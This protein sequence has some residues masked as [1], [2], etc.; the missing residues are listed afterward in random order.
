MDLAAAPHPSSLKDLPCPLPPAG[1]GEPAELAYFRKQPGSDDQFLRLRRSLRET[2]NWSALATLLVLHAASLRD[3]AKVAELSFQAYELW[4]DRAK[5]KAQAAHALVRALQAQPDNV[6]PFDLLRR[7]Y[8]QL[9]AHRELAT[10]LRWRIDALKR[11]DRNAVPAALVELGLLYEQ[12][13]LDIPEACALYRKALELAPGDRNASEQLIR[14][15]MAAGAWL[16]AIDLMNAELARTDPARGA[17]DKARF[18]ELHLRLAKIEAQQL[19]NIPGAALHLQSALKAG[20]DNIAALR[21][22]GVLYLGSGKATDDGLAKAADVFFRAAKLARG[23]G[24]D[25]QALGLLRRTLALKPDHFEAG[26]A[27]AELLAQRERWMELDD[28]YAA[29]L[30]YVSDADSYGLWLQRGELLEH[31]LARREEARA[32][33]ENATRFEPP[34]GDAWQRL[35]NLL[36]ELSDHHGL[37]GLIERWSEQDPGSLPSDRLLRAA[38]IAREELADEERAAVFFFKVLEREPFNAEA[39]EG[40]KEHWRRKANWSHLAD[41]LLYQIDQAQQITGPH[42]PLARSEFAENFV[43]LADIYER[44]LGD[45]DAA[46]GAWNRLAAAYPGDWR[47][48]EQIGRIDKRARMLDNMVTAQEN[49]LV[50]TAEPARRFEVLRRLTQAQRE[51]MTDPQRTITLYH[52]MLS[53]AP[54]DANTLKALGEMYERTGA[55]D[56]VIDLLRRQHDVTRSVSQ[57]VVLLRRMAEIWHNEL[58][59]PREALWACEQ[60]L[61]Y[62]QGDSDALRRM[63]ALCAEL[64]EAAGEFDALQRELQLV[65]EPAARSRILRRMVDVSER[66]LR[67]PQRTAQ[68]CSQ[69][70]AADPHN[71]E[72]LDK[73]IG[74]YE[75]VGR[76]EE[77]ASLLGKAAASAKT[78]PIRQLDYLMRLGNLAETTLADHDLACSA[79]E[80]V[81]RIH[82]DHRGAVEALTRLYRALGSWHGLAAT[83]GTLQEMSD[84]DEDAIA[85]G[86][87]RADVLADHLD[88]PAAAVRVLEQLANT[89]AVGHRDIA[90]KL[91][92]L[93]ERAGQFDK[94]IRHAELMLL[95]TLE[96]DAR[97]E[98]FERIARTWL[99]HFQNQDKALASFKRFMAE[100]EDDSEG[101]QIMGELQGLTGDHAGTLATL[102]RSLEL[103]DNP[104]EQVVTL[105]QMAEVCEQGLG[106]TKRA[107]Q[108]L[109]R[110][111]GIAPGS[112]ELKQKIEAFA[113]RHRMWK[114]LL[115]VYA[116]LF[117]NMNTRGE[118]RSQIDLCV[119]ASA[120]AE[121]R[122]GDVD[123][124]FMWAKKA[125]FVALRAGMDA[126]PVLDRLEGLARGHNLWPQMLEV[127]EQELALQESSKS[128]SYGDYGTIALLMSAAEIARERLRDPARSLGFLT[129]AYKLRPED[130]ELARQIE[131]LAE[132]HGLW[133][134]IIDLHE[135]RLAREATT[136]L[137]RF[138]AANAIAKVY[139]RQ[140]GAPEKAFSYLR[141]AWEDVQLKEPSLAEEIMDL[142]TQ[143]ARR[144]GLWSQL[145]DHNRTLA[146]AKA[147][148]GDARGAL[149]SLREA[150]RIE[151]EQQGDAL[152]ALRSL[153]QAVAHDPAHTV[154]PKVRELSAALDAAASPGSPRLGALALLAVL[155]QMIGQT[156]DPNA[157]INLLKQRAEIREKQLGDGQ[158][159][160]AEWMR[161]LQI[162]AASEEARFEL[163]RL[164]DRDNLW[165]VMLLVPAWELAQKPGK[166]QQTRLLGQIA[167]LYEGP[168]ARPEYALRTRIA[169]W[170]L[171]A[172]GVADLPVRGELSQTHAKLWQLAAVVGSFTAPPAPKDPLL[173][174]RISPPELAD[175]GHWHKLGLHP[176]NFAPLSAGAAAG[177]ASETALLPAREKTKIVD[178]SD[179]EEVDEARPTGE[180]VLTPEEQAALRPPR[181]NTGVVDL[182]DVEELE[183]ARLTGEI[184]L[185]DEQL[186]ALGHKRVR[187]PTGKLALDDVEDIEELEARLTGEIFLTDAEM[188]ALRPPREN[189]GVVDVGDLE[190]VDE[191]PKKREQTNIV[192]I[193]ELMDEADDDLDDLDSLI[194]GATGKVPAHKPGKPALPRPQPGKPSARP[195]APKQPVPAVKAVKT[196]SQKPAAKTV[197]PAV[198]PAAHKPAVKPAAPP[199]DKG[200]SAEALAAHKARVAAVTVG[201]PP[202]PELQ[203]PVLASRPRAASAWDE[204]AAAYATT[205]A[206]TKAERAGVALALARLWNEGAGQ[207]DHAFTH[208]EEALVLT[209]EDTAIRDVLER[210]ADVSSRPSGPDSGG[211]PQRVIDA[212]SRLLGELTVPEHIVGYGLRLAD[213][214]ER[215][216]Q[217]DRAEEQYQAV[218]GVAPRE[219]AALRALARI[220]ERSG[221]D[222]EYVDASTRLLDLEL[223]ELDADARVARTLALAHDLVVRVDR[224]VD[225]TRRLEALARD[226]PRYPQAHERL[227]DLLVRQGL[228]TRAVEALRVA[229]TAVP[230]PEFALRATARVAAL[231]EEQLQNV[232]QA[233]AAWSEIQQRRP[234]DSEAL[235]QLQRL[236]LQTE[237]YGPLLPIVDRR[238]ALLPL[239]DREGRI[240]L[241]VAKARALQEG[242]GN[243][244]AA[245]ETLETLAAEAPENDDVLLGLSR[246][247]RKRGRLDEGLALL[248]RRLV[249]ARDNPVPDSDPD[250]SQ[251]AARILKLSG[252][253]ADALETE[254]RDPRAALAAIDAALAAVPVPE[255]SEPAPARAA[256]VARKVTLARAMGDAAALIDGLTALAQPDGLLEAATLA[257]D[258]VGDRELATQLYTRVL[259]TRVPGDPA[260]QKRLSAAI[261]GLVRLR[262]EAGDI[263]GADALMD[264]QLAEL[265]D[266]ELRARILTEI[267]RTLLASLSLPEP[268]PAAAPGEPDPEPT[269]AFSIARELSGELDATGTF[270]VTRAPTVP[271][272]DDDADDELMLTQRRAD[273]PP[274]LAEPAE[275]EDVEEV[276]A[277]EEVEEL[278]AL[279]DDEPATLDVSRAPPPRKPAASPTPPRPAAVVAAAT[280][281][282]PRPRPVAAPAPTGDRRTTTLQAARRRFEAALAADPDHA[283]ARLSLGTVLYDLGLLA[284]AEPVLES[285][286]EAFGLVRDQENLVQGLCLL[287]RLFEHTDRSAEAYRRLSMALRHDP[288]NLEIRA[289]MARNRYQAGRWRDTL[290]AIEPIEQRLDAGLAVHGAQ[291]ELVSDLLL[292][293]AECD[294]QLKQTDRLVARFE[295]AAA[296]HP[297]SRKARAALAQLC[298]DSGRLAEAAEHTRALAEFEP[299]RIDRGRALMRAGMLFHEAA[300]AT[301]E[302]NEETSSG[303][304]VALRTAA[305][306]CVDLGLALIADEPAASLDRRQLEAAFWTAA[307]RHAGIALT[308]LGRLLGHP[309]LTPEHRHAIL[310]EGARIALARR[311]DGDLERALELATAATV[312]LPLVASGVH[313][314]F[315]AHVAT[316]D[317]RL[318]QIETA[319]LSFF[320]RVGRDKPADAREVQ[321]RQR[322]LARLAAREADHPDRAIRL[323]ERA[324]A[325]DPDTLSLDARRQLAHLYFAAATEGPQVRTNDEA[326]LVLDP[327]DERN[328]A[329][330]A[331]HCADNNDRDRAHALYQVL[332]VVQPAHPDATAFLGKND[333]SHVSNG[334]LD[335]NTVIDKPPAGGGVVAAMTQLWEGAA[336]LICEELPRLEISAAAWIEADSDKDTLLWKVW[337]ELGTQISTTGVR[338]ADAG[339]IP[340]VTVQQWA[341]PRAAHPPIVMIGEIA[342][343]TQMAP[344][345][346]FV[347]GRALFGTRPAAAPVAGL[348]RQLSAT[349][350]AA[351]LQA[352]HP[353]HTRR[354]RVR[355]DADLATRLAQT[356]ARKLPIRLARQLSQFFKDHEAE[357]FDSRDWR[358]WVARSGNRV[359]LCLARNLGVALDVLGLPSD[360]AERSAALKARAAHDADLRDLLVFATRP[361]YVA[362]RKTLGFEVR[363]R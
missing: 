253:L 271:S 251:T 263:E 135:S 43:E 61:G 32:C 317:D 335:P 207:P 74:V 125:Y 282:A 184:L 3:P 229:V 33:Y 305:F 256:L 333:L 77:L 158:G 361:T 260:Q 123:L 330:L 224:L 354:T 341:D 298:E 156:V 248:E 84:T 89:V 56:Q 353:R 5:D 132:T 235:A 288:D 237:Q 17:G 50:R 198:K 219:R 126:G 266:A 107:L 174:P 199:P 193:A 26:N 346:R 68:A 108:L 322:L 347:L 291:A 57:R 104:A 236:Y 148:K 102:E 276:D 118:S 357:A 342:R 51:R 23:Q 59:Q 40:Y 88:N 242:L 336:E 129:R 329:S 21:A 314:V 168:L 30:G 38:R 202:L 12:Q 138:E 142:L 143:L 7:L 48:R 204:L 52:E 133:Q 63:Q 194:A 340:G 273:E 131:T 87:E 356:F 173:W 285:A 226:Y 80:R 116:E 109:G 240:T 197:K 296:L 250:G 302:N 304:A 280:A 351:A 18:A 98:L 47:P 287:G 192:D 115:V 270:S 180:F 183:E 78:P 153:K 349:L 11:S 172:A 345:L 245:L 284:E 274:A 221:R 14:L 140:L 319:V 128:P 36:V 363:Q 76:H 259:A 241:L 262:I 137:A 331:R 121:Q 92:E 246:L 247:V 69:L 249:E 188:A 91:L 269:A 231:C 189:T 31:H 178:I 223:P 44:R 96:I 309:D 277:A 214:Y 243:E 2:E 145:A 105:E 94:L 297:R 6:R 191:A 146:A 258:V 360:P 81:L 75:A 254:A 268:A 70:L 147:R 187:E 185:S 332:R 318:P 265:A 67:D 279:D 301:P 103:A 72:V 222:R 53:L 181:E 144:H 321:D 100:A 175:L 362:A 71:M 65:G 213:L 95:S 127:T 163:E 99:I 139:E 344:P 170:K 328:L 4:N 35:E 1:N 348:S 106:H 60:I 85:C 176:H 150:A 316:P 220:H 293:A 155:Q 162:N 300:G 161:V 13:I 211:Q 182:S 152:A 289:A 97:R 239:G 338:L 325:L 46:L 308:C 307:P 37:V 15:H 264:A 327:L 275:L 208:L 186:K 227:A 62:S 171:N 42:S 216:G 272:D 120:A 350:L 267:G 337:T 66:K 157:K 190:E 324:A 134:A 58:R 315:D 225:A 313:A 355:D 39:F 179:V 124:A 83:L 27:L 281:Q 113:D 358:T 244:A 200:P 201:L 110:A 228:W 205:P 141:R 111:L 290:A 278:E 196:L 159:A 73:M 310:L 218:V 16:P 20:P 49:E 34:G 164:A 90:L 343:K 257:R 22:F 295:R 255:D 212:Y 209:P 19:D 323:L 112:R 210:L 41:L 8:E 10:L 166:A 326:L 154:L 238:L 119:S 160:M 312:A 82:R 54:G 359:G 352:F 215:T 24:D 165:S 203:A 149:V 283:P 232:P 286:V 101:L 234:D 28:L 299:S 303:P 55:Y 294:Q 130:D 252:A 339:L 64:T 25:K 217:L 117:T 177:D 306:E 151:H 311:K 114:D 86:W 261:E 167:E 233:I 169:A 136:G 9:G 292:L 195:A 79:F 29:W 93:Y 320:N 334:K 230:D 122:I 45:L 206:T